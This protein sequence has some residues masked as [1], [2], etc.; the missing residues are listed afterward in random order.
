MAHFFTISFPLPRLGTQSIAVDPFIQWPSFLLALFNLTMAHGKCCCFWWR[1][2]WW[3]RWRQWKWFKENAICSRFDSCIASVRFGCL[4]A[5]SSSPFDTIFLHSIP[6]CVLVLVLFF[7]QI[8]F[9][10]I[11]FGLSIEISIFV[12][13]L[14]CIWI[15]MKSNR[16]LTAIGQSK[17]SRMRATRPTFSRR[18]PSFMVWM[19]GSKMWCEKMYTLPVQI[20]C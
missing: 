1:C 11:S 2:W 7:L 17:Y 6:S 12:V 9:L 13:Y 16:N 8:Y 10:C 4:S 3:W 15:V 18:S 19:W 14:R 5:S 20:E